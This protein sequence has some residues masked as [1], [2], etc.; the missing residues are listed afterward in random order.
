[1]LDLVAAGLSISRMKTLSFA[2][3]LS[4]VTLN[5]A[6]AETVSRAVT[7]TQSAYAELDSSFI[8][9]MNDNHV[10]GLV[11]GIV[12]NGK[13]VHVRGLGSQRLDMEHQPVTADTGFRIAS[14][15]K[16]FTGYAIL[17][18]RDAGKL[19][20]DDPAWDRR[21][22]WVHGWGGPVLEVASPVGKGLFQVLTFKRME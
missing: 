9:W 10:P 2:I 18:L 7:E 15:S 12:K 17:K 11:W 4:V 5:P 14:M 16:A 6:A 8:Q 3:A 13:L 1:M 20:L 21:V 22:R 19:R